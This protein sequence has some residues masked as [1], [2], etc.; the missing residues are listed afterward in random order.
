MKMSKTR[1]KLE[2]KKSHHY[3]AI[4]ILD[5]ICAVL[6]YKVADIS[7]A[8]GKKAE[9]FLQY[10]ITVSYAFLAYNHIKSAK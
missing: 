4:G 5:A 3:L 9:C 8:E 6:W 10:L 7:A 1:K 2:T